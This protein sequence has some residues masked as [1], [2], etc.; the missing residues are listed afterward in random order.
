M[1]Q[2]LNKFDL[3]GQ[4]MGKSL[5]TFV[6]GVLA[7][8]QNQIKWT[9]FFE[10][11][12]MSYS[13]VFSVMEANIELYP[14]ASVIDV[15]SP[16]PKRAIQG[17]S[18]WN[19]EVPKIGHGYDL[20]EK[21]LRQYYI[22]IEAGGTVSTQPI[23]DLFYNTVNKT[24]FGIH[25]R[26]NSMAMQIVSK[27]SLLIDAANNPDGTALTKI[28][29]KVPSTHKLYAGFDNGVGAAWTGATAT[30]LTDIQDMLDAADDASVPYDVLYFS[31]SL[32]RTF[33][34][35]PNVVKEVN[36][37]K[38]NTITTSP[39]TESETRAYMIDMGFPPVVVIDERTGLQTDGVT[40]NVTS[41]DESNIVLAPFGTLG[42]VKNAKPISVPGTT[43]R[44][45]F[46]AD[47]RIKIVEKADDSRVTQGFEAECNAMPVLTKANYM[48]IMDTSTTTAWT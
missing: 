21:D 30:P 5:Q 10:W 11:G 31:K 23:F 4:I 36:A 37:R 22:M 33:M 46:T 19:G 28:D 18:L 44:T 16:K 27:G 42:E 48:Y 15:D 7:T 32:W 9:Q 1:N 34:R 25:A 40:A 41:W 24:E 17:V 3:L 38:A 39:T 26:L 43:T 29:M 45:A 8:R 12:P 13:T 35:H 20:T 6:D 2:N 14:M 47:G